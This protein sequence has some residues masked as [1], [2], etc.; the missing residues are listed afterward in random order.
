L[1]ISTV[2]GIVIG[3]GCL[4]VAV[5][6]EGG[7]LQSLINVPA[8]LIV[9]GGT[10]GATFISFPKE[11]IFNLPNLIKQAFFTRAPMDELATIALMTRL[12]EKARREGLL[13]LEEETDA[14]DDG[15]LK[16]GTQL[17]V[18]GTDPD[19]VRGILE[20]DLIK[21][22]HRHEASYGVLEAMGGYAPTMG[23]IGTV[24]GLVHVLGQ[25]SDPSAL[26]PAIAVAFIALSTEYL[27]P[28]C[29]GYL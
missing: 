6:M 25:L 22:Q 27:Q 26:G 21:M 9:F 18:D 5:L 3:V 20:I 12:A 13:S 14:I 1:D 11:Y 29:C 4:I 8:F 10:I 28:T 23:I 19:M 17:V 24:M 16:R 2:V 7:E 15:F